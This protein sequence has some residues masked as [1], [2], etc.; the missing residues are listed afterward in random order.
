MG[1]QDSSW[2]SCDTW[3]CFLHQVLLTVTDASRTLTENNY[4]QWSILNRRCLKQMWLI[5]LILY[6]YSEQTLFETDVINALD[7][8]VILYSHCFK[9]WLMHLKGTNRSSPKYTERISFF[10]ARLWYEFVI[11]IFLLVSSTCP[12][13]VEV[14]TYTG[15]HYIWHSATCTNV[16]ETCIHGCLIIFNLN[17][18][19]VPHL[20]MSPKCFTVTAIMLLSLCLCFVCTDTHIHRQTHTHFT[21]FLKQTEQRE[22]ISTGQMSQEHNKCPN[23]LQ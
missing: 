12:C 22:F 17:I 9:T 2:A 5:H 6:F 4:N 19:W 1:P 14:N 23:H 15:S 11:N 3:Q 7:F 21:I 18:F 8:E 10:I 20:E 13:H 16:C